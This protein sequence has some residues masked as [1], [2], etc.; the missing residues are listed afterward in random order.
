[1]YPL[2]KRTF[3]I[4]V[5]LVLLVLLSPLLLPLAMLLRV[6]GEGE[7]FYR[8]RRVG[9]HNQH[10][11]IV[12]FA[13]MLKNSANM[14]LGTV[15]VRNDPR[16]TPLGKFLRLSKLN[17]V[18]Q[19]WNILR[20]DMSLV[21]PRPMLPKNSFD[22]YSPNIQARLY[23]IRPGLTGI[24]SVIF[25]DEEKIISRVVAEGQDSLQFYK[26][27]VFPYKGELEMWYQEHAGLITD[28][29]IL[30]ATA[31]TVV[32]HRSQLPRRLFPGL[33]PAP[34]ELH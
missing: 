32:F 5:A 25:R 6:T 28:A 30:F 20:G 4:T 33:P 17:E 22:L 24:G 27:V 3:D 14:G 34:A 21:G 12:K 7:V 18:P 10:F 19:L 26:E 9:L 13:T 11:H 8:Q 2:F 16:I 15:T 29:K 31:W 23:R 1:M